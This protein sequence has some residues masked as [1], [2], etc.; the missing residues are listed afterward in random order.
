MH[1][2]LAIGLGAAGALALVAVFREPDGVVKTVR[3]VVRK[4]VRK[5]ATVTIPAGVR[6]HVATF[7]LAQLV[8]QYR[9]KVPWPVAMAIME[10]ESGC[11]PTIYNYYVRDYSK[12]PKGVLV[13]DAKGRKIL[14]L[15]HAR[16]GA[17]RF[18]GGLLEH[19]PHACGLYQ[20]LDVYRTSYPKLDGTV[21]T[22][23][24][25]FDPA[26]NIQCA[27]R[28]RSNDAAKLEPYAGGSLV[29]FAQLIYFA[30]AEG[31]GKLTGGKHAGAFARLKALGKP[32]TWD[33]LA[34]LPWGASDWW[35]L[36]N[37]LAGIAQVGVRT[38]LW[39]AVAPDA[40]V[41]A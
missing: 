32:V 1:R 6:D 20:I 36:G 11:D 24:E 31:L 34:A 13:L 3:Q 8:E 16:P 9:G 28:A 15:A 21:P 37:R 41:V 7:G 27:L 26:I 19:D 18:G 30:H 10:H 4:E 17:G 14:R 29:L 35:S 22:T 39:A 33:N 12:D 23:A 5:M 25:L 38:A 2:P 40:Q